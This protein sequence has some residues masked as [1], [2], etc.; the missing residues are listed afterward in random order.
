MA[1][2]VSAVAQLRQAP[3][4]WS[5]SARTIAPA[6]SKAAFHPASKFSGNEK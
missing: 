4:S 5:T 1:A 6:V 3:G 2:S